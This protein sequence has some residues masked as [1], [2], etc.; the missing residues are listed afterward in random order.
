MAKPVKLL[1]GL[2]RPLVSSLLVVSA[3]VPPRAVPSPDMLREFFPEPAGP[4]EAQAAGAPSVSGTMHQP[5][6]PG[7]HFAAGASGYGSRES[8]SP[9]WSGLRRARPTALSSSTL[10][11]EAQCRRTRLRSPWEAPRSHPC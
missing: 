8:S 1:P 2:H 4:R 6:L 9:A 11:L 3:L 5:G 10:A 7:L